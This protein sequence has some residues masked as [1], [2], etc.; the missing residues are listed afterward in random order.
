M[1]E[2][3]NEIEEINKKTKV[4]Y[5]KIIQNIGSN[6]KN[7]DKLSKIIDYSIEEVMP[8]LFG[9]NIEKAY[10]NS[11]KQIDYFMRHLI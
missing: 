4:D 10:E 2:G 3:S 5:S 9:K 1:T 7:F 11:K 6:L 8:K